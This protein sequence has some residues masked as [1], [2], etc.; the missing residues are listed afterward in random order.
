M[1]G[2]LCNTGSLIVCGHTEGMAIVFS[3]QVENVCCTSVKQNMMKINKMANF[4]FVTYCFL[5][6]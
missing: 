6:T 5:F 1:V 4:S 3:V 2:D